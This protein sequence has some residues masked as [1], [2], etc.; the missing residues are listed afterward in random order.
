MTKRFP[1][2]IVIER[3]KPN[4]SGDGAGN[5]A[6]GFETLVGPI[7]SD[8]T[9]DGLASNEDEAA[10]Q[11]ASRQRFTV[12]TRRTPLTDQVDTR[13]RITEPKGPRVFD[14]I[15]VEKSDRS[16]FIKFRVQ[17]TPLN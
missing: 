7:W 17:L 9:S 4:P 14:V 5:F 6:A 16:S 3:E 2:R 15:S 11:E 12:E 13:D 1:N 10:G 8:I